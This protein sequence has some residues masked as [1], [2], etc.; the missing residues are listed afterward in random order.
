MKIKLLAF[1]ERYSRRR[2][3]GKEHIRNRFL[4]T[5]RIF[6]Y[7]SESDYYFVYRCDFCKKKQFIPTHCTKAKQP[8]IIIGGYN[9]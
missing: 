8:V 4:H 3:C 2:L 1:L 6:L 9:V 7:E 5:L